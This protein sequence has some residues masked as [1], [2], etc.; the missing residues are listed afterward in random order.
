LRLSHWAFERRLV[1]ILLIVFVQMVGASMVN[2]ILP[3]YA[4][5]AFALSPEVITLLL[6]TFFTAQFVSSPIV[7]RLSDQ[8]G[9]LPVLLLSQVGTVIAFLMIGLAETA[10]ALFIARLLDGITGGNIIVA[11][12]Y[13]T[14]IIPEDKR[15]QALGYVMAAFGVGFVVGPALGGLLAGALGPRVPFLFAA[16]AAAATVALTRFTLEES[17]SDSLRQQ[18]RARQRGGLGLAALLRN[19]QLLLV[20]LLSFLCRFAFGLLI[21]T[22]ALYAEA[23]I[24]AGYAF[25]A[26]SLG[27]GFMLMFVGVGQFITQLALLP[28]ALKYMSDPMIALFGAG[29]RA[30]G[31]F[32]FA[33]ATGPLLGS[34]SMVFIAI[35]SGLLMPALQSL[36]TKTVADEQRGVILGLQQSVMN[37]GVII[38]TGLSGA[39]FTLSP[40]LPNW[41][42][43]LLY[44][45]ALL[46][47]LMLWHWSR[48]QP[49]LAL[50]D[51]SA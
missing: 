35:G 42:G 36:V 39:L 34:L 8:H 23:V 7:G 22:F 20:L 37:L 44:I 51:P 21:G 16:L 38:A 13:V 18:E 24:F 43:G 40:A 27:V 9:R 26:V 31:M 14:D 50:T 1:T 30:L 45:V 46:P 4:Q 33:L 10:A 11:Q 5:S 48:S 41:V 2:P 3:L 15:T 29:S 17:L 28:S 19:T 49:R 12:A 32:L 25:A 6:T 47:G